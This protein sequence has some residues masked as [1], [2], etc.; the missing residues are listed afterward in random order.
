MIRT[1]LTRSQSDEGVA[2]VAAMG[3]ALIGILVASLVIAQT[4]T[5]SNDSGRDRLRTTEIHSAEAAID[6]TMARLETE[7]PCTIDSLDFGNGTQATDVTID[8]Q[9]FNDASTAPIA[10]P[11]GGTPAASPNRATVRATSV[12]ELDSVGLNP[13]RTLE[14]SLSLEPRNDLSADAAIF[15]AADITVGSGFTLSPQLLDQDADVWVD[16]GDWDCGAGST[17]TGSLIV[18][19]GEVVFK[20]AKCHVGGDVWAQ[21]GFQ[22]SGTSDSTYAVDRD[23]TVRNGDLTA[24]GDLNVGG[25]ILVGGSKQGAKTATAVG[26]SKYNVGAAAIR[27]RVPVGIPQINYTPSDWAG[28]TIRDQNDLA[29]LIASQYTVNTAGMTKLKNCEYLGNI[30]TI[31]GAVQLPSTPTLYNL[32][33]CSGGFY[34]NQGF[35]FALN[36]DTVFFV[37]NF[38][39][40]GTLRFF[41]GDGQPHKLWV[42]APYSTSTGSITMQIPITI[43][44]PIES[45]WYAPG[46]VTVQTA[47]SLIGQVYGGDVTINTASDFVYT[48]V[49]VPGVDLVS[50]A[51]SSSG[52][53]VE[54]L[55]KREVS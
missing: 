47:S 25:D 16:G 24:K 19:D 11:V 54:L 7:S 33:G 31:S 35:E 32:Q 55:S 53:V 52:F 2:L 13:E 45:F 14:A 49:G 8:I 3:V 51:Q 38:Q 37:K 41:S 28:F 44:P 22:N 40:Q 15:S 30:K 21:Y 12:G 10:C 48:N 18:P 20:N 4:I 27:N 42:I 26:S 36:A 1:R 46:E 34:T 29:S 50:A 17:I 5:A 43:N 39:S 23:L 6:A 9:Y